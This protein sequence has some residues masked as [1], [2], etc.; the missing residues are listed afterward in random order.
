[1][2]K[3]RCLCAHIPDLDLET[4]LAL[5]MH[6]SEV[7]KTTAT[8]P[9]A[10]A[11]LSNHSLYVHGVRDTPLDLRH[12]H[13]EGR[14]VLV[15]FPSEGAR[16]L[17]ASLKAED[18]RPITLVVPDGN[19]RQASRVPKRIPGLPEAEGV[20]LPEGAPTAWGIRR[21]T[22]SSGLATFEAIARAFG[23]LEAESVQA[24]LQ[25]LFTLMVEAT[26]AARGYD[27][28]GTPNRGHDPPLGDLPIIYEDEH[29]IAINKAP[30]LLVHRG[31]GHDDVP[32][33]AR[34]QA[35]YDQRMFPVHRLDRATSG[36]L[37]FARSSEVARDM[38]R[39]F[40]D[41]G[42]AKRYLALCRGH[43]ETLKQVDHPLAREKGEKK[44]PA[45][46]DFRLL[47]QFERYGLFE[48]RPRSGRTHQIRRHLKHASHPIIG[49]VRYGKAE[50]NRIFRDHFSF[51]RMALH[52]ESMSFG[53]PR[54]G[55]ALCIE[56]TVD[57]DFRTLLSQLGLGE[58]V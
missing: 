32:V 14:R 19:W 48:A 3:E 18:S 44:R 46:T 20:T 6:R 11:A 57:G 43:D 41:E 34:L 4:R 31:W 38:Q 17:S 58:L 37:L 54:T 28:E 7:Q 16:P 56:A 1:M 29:L 13:Q 47:G 36:V 35:Q 5:V 33:V 52:C 39:L 42:I 12:L 27:K 15:L 40:D 2:H 51:H 25:S 49:D 50:H 8:G 21:E 24:Q 22:K 30:G 45:V 23:I 26:H 10:L 55:E 9:L 53:H